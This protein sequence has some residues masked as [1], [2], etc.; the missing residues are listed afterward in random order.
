MRVRILLFLAWM[1]DT[2]AGVL[3]TVSKGLHN[4]GSRLSRVGRGEDMSVLNNLLQQIIDMPKRCSCGGWYTHL[5]NQK[6]LEK[7]HRECPFG[8]QYDIGGEG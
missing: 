2:G 4:L 6:H 8:K 5:D 7:H 3:L 1:L